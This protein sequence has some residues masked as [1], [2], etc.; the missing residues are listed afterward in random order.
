MSYVI[1]MLQ[2]GERILFKT[3][4]SRIAYLNALVVLAVMMHPFSIMR[5]ARTELALTDKRIIGATGIAKRA[6]VAL[7]FRQ[8]E[9]VT[10]RSGLLGWVLDYGNVTITSKDG[11][12]VTFKGIL[13]P[14]VFQQEADEA[15]ELAV[16]GRKLSDYAPS[17]F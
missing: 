14:L 7:P 12:R 1:D 4:V 6:T 16:L 17:E 5:L 10:V 2:P 9:S 11:R 8:I 15:I 3:Q 13:W